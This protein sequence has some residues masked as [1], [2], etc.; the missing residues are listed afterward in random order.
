MSS[1]RSTV[2][3]RSF[4]TNAGLPARRAAQARSA[5][6]WSGVRI[7]T[8]SMSGRAMISYGSSVRSTPGKCRAA[9][10]R[11]AGSGSARACTTA[12][13]PGRWAVR[14]RSRAARIR[15][16]RGAGRA[17]CERGSQPWRRNLVS[18]YALRQPAQ[19]TSLTHCADKDGRP[20][21][22]DPRTGSQGPQVPPTPLDG[23]DPCPHPLVPHPPT[24]RHLARHPTSPPRRR[25]RPL[26]LHRLDAGP[27]GGACRP[28]A[29][30]ARA[31]C[32]AGF[33]AVPPA[34][35]GQLVGCGVGRARGV[36]AIVSARGVQDRRGPRGC[37]PPIDRTVRAGSDSGHR[38]GLR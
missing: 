6:V 26:A 16:C 12:P 18:A 5:C 34:G 31:V 24:R 13:C 28:V 2:M 3:S 15:G 4:S 32:H 23:A 37:G 17:G 35:T 1:Q 27:L 8:T 20:S 36:R 9:R 14:A 30:R 33:R 22:V 19:W 10:V 38:P 29:G 25:P 21:A 7:S 11:A